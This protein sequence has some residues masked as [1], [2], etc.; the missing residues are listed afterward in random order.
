MS[1]L[2]LVAK[3]TLDTSEYEKGLGDAE[4]KAGSIGGKI[5]GGLSKI[6][7]VGAIAFGAVT[8]A[9]GAM[10]T[11]AVS[12][13]ARY[14]QL[15]GGVNKLYGEAS[16]R[17][18]EYADKA[19]MTAGM[20]ANAYM[21]TATGFSAALIN[22]LGGDT[23]KAADLTD[24]AMRAMSDNVNTFGSSMESVKFAFQG[25]AKQNYT[26][27]DNLKLGYGGTK[28][29][30][31][32]LID[33]ANAWG[34]A[35]G[36]ASDLSIE[37][38][39]D[40]V[41]AIQM[42]QEKQGIAGTTNLEAMKTLEGSANATKAA[43]ENV[44]TSIG[45]GEG[46]G[47]AINNLT[48]AMF[49]EKEG[50]GLLNQIVPR[51]QK[52]FEGIATLVT[53]A[54]PML[55]EKIPEVANAVIPSLL[56][57]AVGVITTLGSA[58]PGLASSLL[59]AV[60]QVALQLLDE[61]SNVLSGYD[62]SS[63]LSFLT[64]MLDTI[65]E[66]APQFLEKGLSLVSSLLTGI[67]NAMPGAVQTMGA[68][69]QYLV[70]MLMQGAPQFLSQGVEFIMNLVSGIASALPSVMSAAMDVSL[71]IINTILDN[72][73]GVIDSGIQI[74]LS[75][76]N[77]LVD[78]LPDLLDTAMTM[79]EG[80]LSTISDN[81][82]S[83][84]QKGV[85]IIAHIV[86]GILGALPSVIAS[87][88][89]LAVQFI[90]TIA[91]HFPSI[92]SKGAEIVGKLVSGIIGAVPNL[93][94][95]AIYGVGQFIA[96]VGSKLGEVLAKGK[97]IISNL[98][99]GVKNNVSK[100]VSTV[101]TIFS[102][103]KSA[104][105]KRDWGSIGSNIINGIK[106]GITN[107]LG[108]LKEAAKDAAKKA[109]EAAKS[110]LGIKSPSRL[111]RDKVGKMMAEG[112]A[113][114]FENEVDPDDYED[115]IEPLSDIGKDFSADVERATV[116]VERDGGNDAVVAAIQELAQAIYNTQ[117]VLDTGEIVGSI[118]DPINRSLGRKAVIA[119]RS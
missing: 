87:A 13:Y 74:V 44:I 68:V 63:I 49:G 119:G 25:F 92:L 32:R 118:V 27:L 40:V 6:A 39:A 22:S 21:E 96:G 46:I 99:D 67:L 107:G 59:S 48:S 91:S 100:I 20:S 111:F 81:L 52:T 35:N 117:M 45:R 104:I 10:A 9:V 51:I 30:M 103:F 101:T 108:K 50:E 93:L 1:L 79:C 95:A 83:M 29:E 12:S 38:F 3:L 75:L 98:A 28:E 36:R 23:K 24:V 115:A 5:A 82:P 7:K 94:I 102:D 73:P 42:I 37:S 85:E 76:I 106:N 64:G 31:K 33:D 110:F 62:T 114:G 57:T 97:E 60:K 116:T 4:A 2:D 15:V 80:F 71:S 19:Y 89:S 16:S 14:E 41:T 72:L 88:V 66:Q 55:A 11:G 109:F 43:W 8:T 84:L 112:M 53:T 58:L 26:M 54:G 56:Q 70:S 113:I 86:T 105:T 69:V 34:A 78:T 47:D 90:S 65:S 18:Q 77:G 61:I 17:L